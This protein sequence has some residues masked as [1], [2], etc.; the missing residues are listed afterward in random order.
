VKALVIGGTGPT[1]HF[2][3][4]GL[5]ARGYAVTI[6]HSGNHEVKEIPDDV[7]HIHTNAFDGEK[8]RAAVRGRG[9]DVCVAT[10]GRL[11]SVAEVTVGQVGRFIS[12]GG[13]PALRGYINPELFD[14]PGLPVP[15]DE[16]ATVVSSEEEDPKG[17]RIAWTEARVFE[18]HPDA[19]HF[20]YPTVYGAYQPAPREWCIV[21]RIIDGRS[22]IVLPEDGLTLDHFGYAENVAHALLLAVDQPERSAGQIYNAAD[23]EILSL[24]QVVETISA[25]LSDLTD[26]LEIVSMPYELAIPARPL[27]MLPQ[28]THRVMSIRKLQRDLGYKDVVSPKVGLQRTAR[29]LVENPPEPGGLEETILQDPFDYDAEDRLVDAWR[30]AMRA[31][32][33]IEWKEPPGYG[34]AYTG[35]GGR[36]MEHRRFER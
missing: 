3:V 9:F 10:Y 19:S 4:N 8:V 35:P 24:R 36:T 33:E 7:E 13:L 18:C 21:R 26:G 6:L 34:L 20:R 23:Q 32:P 29:W 27:M 31:M 15:T 11:R 1:G 30:K 12:V 22:V 17:Y 5:R 28:S 14:P 16:D 25:S 2:L